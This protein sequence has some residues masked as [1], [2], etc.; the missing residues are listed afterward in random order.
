MM[1]AHKEGSIKTGLCKM[2]PVPSTFCGSPLHFRQLSIAPTQM[3]PSSG[4]LVPLPWSMNTPTPTPQPCLR[5]RSS[6]SPTRP[7]DPLRAAAATTSESILHPPQMDGRPGH[8]LWGWSRVPGNLWPPP[9]WALTVKS[10]TPG[11]LPA[12][13]RSSRIP[14]LSPSV[15]AFRGLYTT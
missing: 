12:T 9:T 15:P 1:S 2:A 10:R 8:P 14:G 5:S 7:A 13:L 3:D 11:F 4:D 6:F